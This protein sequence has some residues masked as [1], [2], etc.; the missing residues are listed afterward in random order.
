MVLGAGPDG[1]VATDVL[2]KP[3]LHHWDG[4]LSH[5]VFQK[6]TAAFHGDVDFCPR[7]SESYDNILCFMVTLGSP[8][9][10]LFSRT[11]MGS[12]VLDI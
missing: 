7:E 6:D 9:G 2:R 11:G 8:C 5:L 3:T 4:E 1:P 12:E 10:Q